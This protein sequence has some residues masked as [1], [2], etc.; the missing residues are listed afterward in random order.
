MVN[1]RHE[2]SH[3]WERVVPAGRSRYGNGMDPTWQPS[4]WPNS[5]AFSDW[6]LIET[7]L[8][9]WKL[10]YRPFNLAYSWRIPWRLWI[11]F[12]STGR[13]TRVLST[14]W[15]TGKSSVAGR[16]IGRDRS[17]L[18]HAELITASRRST[19][20]TKRSDD[21]GSPWRTP[22]RQWNSMPG[23]PLTR[24]DEVHGSK[25]SL[26]QLTHR[27]YKANVLEQFK[28]RVVFN[29]IKRLLKVQFEKKNLAPSC[30]T[31]LEE[32][33]SPCQAIL[34]GMSLD[35]PILVLIH[36]LKYNSL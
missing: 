21:R 18:A 2:P 23:T 22:H 6:R 3:S 14:Y 24:T 29:H 10:I 28:N 33:K 27:A 11:R 4:I 32:L 20:R 8:D 13:T 1:K 19:A 17:P 30:L 15:I 5:I 35:E 16:L 36:N 7:K 9:W 31:L 26:I 25:I 12:T 34:D